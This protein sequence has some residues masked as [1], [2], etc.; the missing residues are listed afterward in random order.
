MRAVGYGPIEVFLGPY[1]PP[2]VEDHL[3]QQGVDGEIIV[4]VLENDMKRSRS[5]AFSAPIRASQTTSP[6]AVR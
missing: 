1:V 5:G 2:L 3:D 6:M 4:S